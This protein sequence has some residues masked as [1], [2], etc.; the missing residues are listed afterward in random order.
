MWGPMPPSGWGRGA[1][2]DQPVTAGPGSGSGQNRRRSPDGGGGPERGRRRGAAQGG[3]ALFFHQPVQLVHDLA[4]SA[5]AVHQAPLGVDHAPAQ[6][7][8]LLA[9]SQ[10]LHIPQI[11]GL[12][13]DGYAVPAQGFE[14]DPVSPELGEG[15]GQRQRPGAGA[16][17]MTA[18][19]AGRPG[20][21]SLAEAVMSR[22]TYRS[23]WM[24]RSAAWKKA[25]ELPAT[26]TVEMPWIP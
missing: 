15:L 12:P 11:D 13:I 6:G 7:S 19:P 5:P 18:L 21:P 8:R 16:G 24:M 23:I 26:M 14:L 2:G 9:V 25:P 10:L 1:C 22:G 4:Q 17:S 20:P 3:Q